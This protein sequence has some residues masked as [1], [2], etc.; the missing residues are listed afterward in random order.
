[1]N[2]PFI[3]LQIPENETSSQFSTFNSHK[4]TLNETI[5]SNQINK[6]KKENEKE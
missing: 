4:N 1:M 3:S 6:K 2:N 5:K